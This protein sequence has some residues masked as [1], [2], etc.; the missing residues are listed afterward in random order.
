M[1]EWFDPAHKLPEDGQECLLM[2]HAHDG[3]VTIG[4]FGPIIWKAGTDDSPGLWVDL[5]REAQAGAIVA[6]KDV[7]CWTLWEPIAPPEGLPTPSQ[8]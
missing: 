7:G 6:P 1:T 8:A 4:V 2:P 5:F 3:L